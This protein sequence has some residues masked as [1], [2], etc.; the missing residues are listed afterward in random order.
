MYRVLPYSLA[1]LLVELPYLLAQA[2]AYSAM[3]YWC[4]GGAG[5]AGSCCSARA[6][7]L[8]SLAPIIDRFATLQA[9]MVS[10]AR[11]PRDA[12]LDAARPSR[13]AT[14]WRL[15]QPSWAGKV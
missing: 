8:D 13:V 2:V 1:L 7:P 15:V 9:V 11:Y 6:C 10:C 14:E 4:G 12:N 3:V 5:V